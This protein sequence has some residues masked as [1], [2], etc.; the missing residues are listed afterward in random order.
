MKYNVAIS[1]VLLTQVS[2]E[3]FCT[4]HQVWFL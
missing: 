1:P 3:L 2:Q 4:E